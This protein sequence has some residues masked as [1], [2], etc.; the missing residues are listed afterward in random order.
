M[1]HDVSMTAVA[2]RWA[3]QCG[4]SS[5]EGSSNTNPQES[6]II[7]SALADVVFDDPRESDL[8]FRKPTELR[9]VFRFQLDEEDVAILSGIASMENEG[10]HNDYGDGGENDYDYDY[11][12]DGE[13]YPKIDFDNPKFWL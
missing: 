8:P 11:D 3:L 12:D 1:K 5:G 13:G 10:D 9:Q 7:S 2:L 4:G 6:V